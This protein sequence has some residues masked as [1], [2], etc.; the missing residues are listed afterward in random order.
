MGSLSRLVRSLAVRAVPVVAV[1]LGVGG[2]SSATSEASSTA[3]LVTPAQAQAVIATLW[4]AR[5]HA[6]DTRDVAT[7]DRI[8][9]G[10]AL[11]TD[12]EAARQVAC[13]CKKFYWTKGPRTLRSAAIFLSLQTTYPVD[14]AAE[15]LAARPSQP[16]P[17]GQRW[18]A[19]LLLTKQAADQPWRIAV[20]IFDVGYSTPIAGFPSPQV[21][22]NGYQLPSAMP[23]QVPTTDWFPKLAAYFNG[24]KETG[25]QPADTVF[26]PGPLT[27][28]NG[29]QARPNGF[30]SHGLKSTYT[31]KSSS[32]GGP[33]L[34][35]SGGLPTMCGDVVESV[36]TRPASTAKLLYQPS[37]R[38]NWGPD[39]APG[40]YFSLTTLWEWSVCI[41][42]DGS[43]LAVGGNSAGGYPVHTTGDRVAT[44]R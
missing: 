33:W 25:R 7:F 29:L 21:A 2:I 8:D 24:I 19:M 44:I 42:P 11:L 4:Q 13:G 38:R 43:N 40:Y 37:T 14:F 30:T 32:F 5:E 23:L 12:T 41:Y 27:S 15:V 17:A 39:V 10:S 26:A 35:N 9:T 34:I 31:F 18:T 3:A 22:A 20:E 28:R 16:T 6:L 36:V 1:A